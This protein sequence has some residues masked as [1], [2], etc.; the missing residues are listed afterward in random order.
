MMLEAV[1][2]RF[3]TT[4]A[5]HTIEHLS[6]NGSAYTARETRLFA[7]ALTL[8]PCFTSVASPKSNGMSEAFV[9]TRKRDYVRISPLP[10]TETAPPADRWMD[11]RL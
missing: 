3:G 6:D 1:E 7:Q 2:K 11:R 9:T 5:S 10:Y 4:R 8:V